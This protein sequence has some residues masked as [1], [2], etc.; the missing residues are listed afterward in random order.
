VA[1]LLELP[2]LGVIARHK[3]LS[4]LPEAADHPRSPVSEAYRA[5]RSNIQFASV[6]QPLRTLLVTSPS[7]EDGKTT[8]A[9]NLAVSMAQDGR[10]VVLI[11]ADL[12]KPQVHHSCACPTRRASAACSSSP[13]RT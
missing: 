11:D 7:P 1:R 4:G 9:A 3:K 12:R 5:L 10:K 13:T 6:D 8:V 2:V